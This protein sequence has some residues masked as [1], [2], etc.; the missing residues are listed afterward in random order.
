M[1]FDLSLLGT[2]AQLSSV[3]DSRI[4]T[5]RSGIWWIEGHTGSGKLFLNSKYNVY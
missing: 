5:G 2:L 4:L 1:C 3:T